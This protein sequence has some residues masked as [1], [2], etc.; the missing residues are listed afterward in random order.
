[1]IYAS[2]VSIHEHKKKNGTNNIHWPNASKPSMPLNKEYLWVTWKHCQGL[3]S[4]TLTVRHKPVCN[5]VNKN[6]QKD[7]AHNKKNIRRDEIQIILI[8]NK[9]KNLVWSG[10]L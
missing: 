9:N 7:E 3:E 1:M 10:K 5:E 8:P 6:Y 4:S 2:F